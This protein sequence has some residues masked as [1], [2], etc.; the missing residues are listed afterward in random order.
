MKARPLILFIIAVALF[1][2]FETKDSV[3]L[4]SADL[5]SSWTQ[6]EDTPS[7]TANSA[8]ASPSASPQSEA[9]AQ[10]N[11]GSHTLT[12]EADGHFYARVTADNQPVRMMVDTGASVVALTGRD[13]RALGI[14]WRPQDLQPVARGANG[15]VNGF[16]ITLKRMDLGRLTLTDVQA[17]VIPDGLPVSLLGQSFLNRLSRMEVTG[18]RMTLGG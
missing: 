11:A 8:G 13:A 6:A 3:T 1:V 10:W 17:I 18:D 15:M 7:S 5:Q 4:Q 16:P 14:N 2:W 12:R 9:T